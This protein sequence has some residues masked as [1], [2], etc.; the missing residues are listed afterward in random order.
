MRRRLN[1][2]KNQQWETQID[3]W[4]ASGQS[5]RQWCKEHSISPST[6][7]YW[8]NKIS[9]KQLDP[10][11]FVEIPSEQSTGGIEIRCQRFEIHVAKEFDLITFSRCLKAIR[12]FF[13]I[14][15]F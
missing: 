15:G 14:S 5:A 7:K 10:R 9:P 13:L 12:S 8:Q 6:F 3:T 1:L 11:A 4:K 2:P